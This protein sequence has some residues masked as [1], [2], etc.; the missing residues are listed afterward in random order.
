MESELASKD[1][2]QPSRGATNEWIRAGRDGRISWNFGR[3]RGRGKPILRE[4]REDYF[5]PVAETHNGWIMPNL[6]NVMTTQY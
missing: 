4:H 5:P 6:L 2:L 1:Q 3:E